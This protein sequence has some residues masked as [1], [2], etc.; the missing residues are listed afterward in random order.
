MYNKFVK[1]QVILSGLISALFFLFSWF[2]NAQGGDKNT[3]ED[4]LAIRDDIVFHGGFEEGYNTTSWKNRWGIPWI[5]RAT[6]NEIVT[7]HFLGEKSL[8]VSYP[9]GGVGPGETGTQFPLVFNQM[10]GLHESHFNEIYLRYYL[11][12]EE[13]FDFRLGGKLPGL[14]GGGNSWSRSGGDQPDGTNGWTMRF[15]WRRNG[16]IVVY[17]YLPPSEN[18][19]WGGVQ[20]G[21]DINCGFTAVPGKWHCIEQ[22]INV[23]TPGADDG[24]LKVWIDGVQRLDIDDMRFWDIEN[25]YGL[26]GGVYFSTFHGGNTSDWA[27]RVDSYAQYDGIVMARNR[28]GPAK[29][30]T[31]ELKPGDIEL[32][33]GYSGMKYRAQLSASGGAPPYRWY[34]KNNTLPAGLTL[35][36]E[37]KISGFPEDIVSQLVNF[38]V[39]DQLGQTSFAEAAITISP[40]ENAN[41]AN[42]HSIVGHSN[43]FDPGSPVE[44]LWDG[45]V[46]GQLSASPGSGESDSFWVEYDFGKP[47]R[48][49]M[50]RFFGES[51][52]ERVSKFYTVETRVSDTDQWFALINNEDCFADHW[53]ET[54]TDD[55]VRY[56]RLT[57]SGDKQSGSVRARAFEVYTGD[58]ET[59]VRNFS[60]GQNKI[61]H[62]APNPATDNINISFNLDRDAL[63]S[64]DLFSLQ[65]I[66]TVSLAGGELRAGKHE[67][68]I[69]LSRYIITGNLYLLVLSA[70]SDSGLTRNSRILKVIR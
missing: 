63:V 31:I 24:Q 47:C 14:M 21:Q 8:R 66:K 13:G 7:N 64:I 15:M 22:Y 65:G 57:V 1:S 35:S 46:S 37:G 20:W 54:R 30:D 55:S 23:G 33:E 44:G 41:L 4:S 12:F 42:G 9:K 2:A 25:D 68:N 69:D 48:V 58:I 49:S 70:L 28:V 53:L 51:T 3:L 61:F 39:T 43:N 29:R 38:K 50:I 26:I 27:P 19:K 32:P 60:T 59:S 11:K 40:G 10:T 34:D 52:G 17:A 62:I 67:L 56:V 18:G 5:Q 6:I 16:Q 36:S 45:D